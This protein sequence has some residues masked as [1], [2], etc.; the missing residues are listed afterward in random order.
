MFYGKTKCVLSVEMP[1]K[2]LQKMIFSNTLLLVVL[3]EKIVRGSVVEIALTGNEV[4]NMMEVLIISPFA[5]ALK[6]H[7]KKV[8]EKL[9]CDDITDY[10]I[11]L[12]QALP[13]EIERKI[14]GKQFDYAYIDI[15][16]IAEEINRIREH[17]TGSQYRQIERF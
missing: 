15:H 11:N 7:E 17:I 5:Y 4:L 9:F 8:K 2:N 13:D 14:H 12:I 10:H 6:Q 3:Q 16:Y 1:L